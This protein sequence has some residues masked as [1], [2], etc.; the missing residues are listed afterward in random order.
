MKMLITG[1]NGQVG[2]A[3][4]RQ[5][6][7]QGHDVIAI[8]REQ[9]DMAQSPEYGEELVLKTKPDLV[10]NPAAY[11]NVDGA[12]EDEAVALKV[13]ADAPRA[14]A[15]GCQQLDI[16]IFQVSTDYVFDGSKEEPYVETDKTNPTKAQRPKN[17]ALSS[18]KIQSDLINLKCLW[19][20][21]IIK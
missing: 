6:K 4:V 19:R 8:S 7:V 14:L 5:A 15:R 13:N 18:S 10:I 3:L 20:K 1:I 16:P 11:T 21:E 2:S 17:S 12:E 9:W